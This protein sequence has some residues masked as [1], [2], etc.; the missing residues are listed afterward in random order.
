MGDVNRDYHRRVRPMSS[1]ANATS[2]LTR[3]TPQPHVLVFSEEPFTRPRA[4]AETRGTP[5][6]RRGDGVR[7]TRCAR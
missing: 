3:R 6:E 1:T 4:M 5:T 2:P 7:P